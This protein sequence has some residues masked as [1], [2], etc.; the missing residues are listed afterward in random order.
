MEQIRKALAHIVSR[1]RGRRPAEYG[2]GAVVR[3]Y[4]GDWEIRDLVRAEIADSVARSTA[5][6]R[7]V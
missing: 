1:Y 5:S 2:E 4:V 3:V 6:G 7:R